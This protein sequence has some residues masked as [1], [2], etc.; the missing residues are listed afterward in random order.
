[1]PNFSSSEDETSINLAS[2]IIC[3]AGISTFSTTFWISAIFFGLAFI[4]SLLL[5]LSIVIFSVIFFNKSWTSDALAYFNSII[6]GLKPISSFNLEDSATNIELP[7][8]S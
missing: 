2:N 3:N 8:T 6:W 1:M 4:R 7:F 5:D